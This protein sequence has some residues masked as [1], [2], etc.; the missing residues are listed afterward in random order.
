[1]LGKQL[2]QA[3]AGAAGGDSLYVDDVF[4]TYLYEGNGSAR[5][6]A[7][8]IDLSGE[9]GLVWIKNRDDSGGW[10]LNY[11]FDTERSPTNSDNMKYLRSDSTNGESNT[12]T[13]T[14]KDFGGWASNGF[15]LGAPF[16]LGAD[17]LNNSAG[18]NYVSWTLRKAPGFFD[19][20]KFT[21]TGSA[22]SIPHNLG[23]VPGFIIVKNLD[24]TGGRP[25]R[26]YHSGM[27]ND[28]YLLL[29]DDALENQHENTWNQTDPTSTHFT[30]GSEG[31]VN[32]LDDEHIAYLF[33]DGS[34][35]ASAV[36]GTDSDEKIIK[37]GSYNGTG[38][39]E[40]IDCGFEPQWVLIKKIGDS[41]DANWVIFDVMREWNVEND[42]HS[43]SPNSYADEND[44]AGRIH[45][46]P[47]GFKAVSNDGTFGSDG[48]EYMYVAIRRPHKPPEAGTD[49]LDIA[50]RT[51][52][53]ST[54]VV[55]T[56]IEPVD[57]VIT[58]STN[59]TNAPVA[60]TR[61]LGNK[62][63][64]INSNSD[65]N[66]NIFGSSMNPWD[67]QDGI[68]FSGDGDTNGGS[69]WTYINY[70]F[71]RAPGFFDVVTYEAASGDLTVNHNLG[72]TPEM[73]IV[74]GRN[75]TSAWT[76][77]HSG[78]SSGTASTNYYIRLDSNADESS[79][80]VAD[81]VSFS[82]TNFVV[83]NG[84][85]RTNNTGVSGEYIAYLFASLNG[86]SKV[87]T[88]NGTGN[89]VNV[90]CGFDAGARFVLIKRTDS[91]GD[92]YVFDSTRGIEAGD[93]PWIA[94]NTNPAGS[95]VTYNDFID[96]YTSGFTVNS[97]APDALNANEGTYL[98]LAIA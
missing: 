48:Y 52:T 30:V 86:I 98:F 97:S 25:W 68:R 2:T 50:S 7:N 24:D 14:T 76:V 6:I 23:C 29:N 65:S 88:Y 92:W 42:S 4:S 75:Y 53:G 49:V 69:S 35:A 33:A 15:L 17:A 72:V 54:T 71:R 70:F 13:D 41:F 32:R 21:G 18:D 90:D 26:C 60:L 20:V 79:S 12:N 73:V 84:R 34:D 64:A 81:F 8:G 77:W 47:T 37:C 59:Q 5:T 45:P 10:A 1:M 36:F 9:G 19:V 83:G 85:S 31:D 3:A 58:K 46:T 40:E 91:T 89:D 74:K 82:S 80:A 38:G 87:G 51:G 57:F 28:H 56:N 95:S 61:L 39:A 11:L 96:P 22:Q 55:N 44:G 27:G 16:A 78:L 67:V 63:N 93:D 43:L 66:T 94:L 62:T